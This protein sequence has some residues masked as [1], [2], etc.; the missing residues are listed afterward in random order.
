MRFFVKIISQPKIFGD[1]ERRALQRK[2]KPAAA[3]GL[4]RFMTT[5][6]VINR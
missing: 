1:P 4:K 3:N 5:P 2:K 6:E